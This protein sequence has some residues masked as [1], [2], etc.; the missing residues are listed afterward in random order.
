MQ[1][2]FLISVLTLFSLL[3]SSA[4]QN[5]LWYFGINAAIS[6]NGFGGQPIPV[7]V[8]NSVMTADEAAGSISDENG[9]LLFYTN[10]I[11]VYN[12]LHQVMLNG[13]NLD[14][15]I[16]SAQL[17]IVPMPG[18][19][20]LFFIFTTGCIENNFATG[21]KYSIVD[22]SGDNGNGQVTSKNSLLW[23]SCTER[24]TAARHSNGNDVWVITND[25][26][27]NIF[28]SWLITCTGLQ[29]SP[30][31]S[32][33]G[34]IMD[35]HVSMNA[36]ILK[37]SPDGKY[38][39]QTSFP[40]PD[41]IL[42]PPNFFQLFDFDN[43]TGLISNDR[44]ISFSD[45]RYT[46]CEFSP[47]SRLLYLTRPNDKMMDQL[48][49]TLPTLPAIKASRVS[50]DTQR[51]F[52]SLQSADDDKI[53]LVQRT[54]SLSVIN[55]PNVSG[56]GC[57]FRK[58]Q[59]DLAPGTSIFG[60]PSFINDL[61][62][63]NPNNGFTISI[64]DSCAGIVQFFGK[65]T[66]SGTLTW[67]WDFGDGSPT[68]SLQ[69]P[70]HTFT[71]PD[72]FYKVSLKV[73]SSI[74]CGVMNRSR[75]F[76]PSGITANADFDFISRCDS[77]YVRFINKSF[78]W[79]DGGGQ[80]EWDFGD[81]T[82]STDINPIHSYILP[83]NYQVNLKLTTTLP[84]LEKSHSLFVDI[85]SLTVQASPDQT[86]LVGQSVSIFANGPSG[87]SYQWSPSTWL[88]NNN[89]SAPQSTPLE[90]IVYKVTAT[91]GD[92]CR[93][94][95][96]VFIRVLQFDDI[97]V[98]TG[99][100]PNNDGKNDLLIPYYNGKLTLKEF[101]IFNRWGQRVY[102]TSQR[103]AGWNGKINGLLQDSSVYIW[104]FKYTD[105]KGIIAEKKGTVVLI[106]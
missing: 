85:Q 106:R 59:V 64:L 53:Y 9:N 39:C 34:T 58:D 48:Q 90:D 94:E 6:F 45:A 88:N 65:S 75:V 30:V 42:H 28:R 11:T 32:T 92:G 44:N 81:G 16:S 63:S 74:S 23:P 43:S 14:G 12:R 38:L 20:N 66:M 102:T 54:A 105:D 17:S 1:K 79:I 101:S 51:P 95:D 78:A 47:D 21:Y 19:N 103:G 70:V 72:Q 80:F 24:I 71:P 26:N 98:P 91:N 84:C 13:D 5:N 15:N 60:L 46:H 7:S 35:Q 27:S 76:Q 100:T 93:S 25:N 82:T 87:S 57:D 62:S 99:F 4:Q 97:Y 69:N 8:S 61:S 37:V 77:G 104:L 40:E 10:G 83:G 22:M 31:V 67:L 52:Y 3:P 86:I 68:S 29:L 50:Y 36:G 41:N 89:T 73:T 49:I 56:I 18:N 2:V 33:I 96:S 55:K